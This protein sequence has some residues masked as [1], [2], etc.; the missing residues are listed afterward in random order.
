MVFKLYIILLMVGFVQ[1][2]EVQNAKKLLNPQNYIYFI[3]TNS[4]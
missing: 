3:P 1:L 2:V 4:K